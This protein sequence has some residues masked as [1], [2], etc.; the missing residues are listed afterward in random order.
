MFFVFYQ[1]CS[2]RTAVNNEK[3]NRLSKHAKDRMKLV[4]TNIKWLYVCCCF[5]L[6]YLR[7]LTCKIW[8]S[9]A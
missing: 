1:K 3:L 8:L 6:E 7:D 9:V 4:P 2:E 5:R